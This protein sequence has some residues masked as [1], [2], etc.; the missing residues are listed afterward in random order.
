MQGTYYSSFLLFAP[1]IQTSPLKYLRIGQPF[2]NSKWQSLWGLSQKPCFRGGTSYLQ[3]PMLDGRLQTKHHLLLDLSGPLLK[4]RDVSG[5]LLKF[6]C[7]TLSSQNGR[8]WTGQFK[9]EGSRPVQTFCAAVSPARFSSRSFLLKNANSAGPRKG[10]L[11]DLLAAGYRHERQDFLLFCRPFKGRCGSGK[12]LSL[13]P[14]NLYSTVTCFPLTRDEEL[15][16][17]K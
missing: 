17:S 3:Q 7:G 14:A 2:K 5:P 12:R 9:G 16:I 1:R 15:L 13:R 6:L 8:S 4:L 10:G 11:P